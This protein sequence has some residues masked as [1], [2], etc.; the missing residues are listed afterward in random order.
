MYVLIV[1]VHKHNFD[2]ISINKQWKVILQCYT[3][4]YEMEIL[5]ILIWTK[6]NTQ[7]VRFVSSYLVFQVQ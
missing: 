6:L 3:L 2:L 5:K 4:W 7:P 1:Q